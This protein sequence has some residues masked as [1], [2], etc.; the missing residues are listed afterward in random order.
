MAR[1]LIA[2]LAD[3]RTWSLVVTRSDMAKP[4]SRLQIWASLGEAA[5]GWHLVLQLAKGCAERALK[6]N[7]G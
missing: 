7:S 2:K 5:G 3:T 1:G 4:G 6:L